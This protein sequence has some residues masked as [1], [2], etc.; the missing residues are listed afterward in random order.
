MISIIISSANSTLLKQVSKN[1]EATI[2]VPFE[3]VSIDN[4][5]GKK[6]ICEV[7]NIG[8][9]KA[10]YEI[11]CFMHEDILIETQNWGQSIV[12]TFKNNTDLGLLGV[13]GS[14]Y[15]TITP[16][17][18]GGLGVN[19]YYSNLIQYHKFSNDP[20]VH[21]YRNPD[22]VKLAPVA[23]VDG[24]W[25]CTTKTVAKEIMFDEINF[26]GFHVYDLDF[27]LSVGQKYKVAVTYDVLIAHFSEGRFDERWMMDC[28]KLH[29]KWN[30]VLPVDCEQLTREERLYTEKATFKH[31][32]QVL[33]K[34]KLPISLASKMLSVNNSF[35]KLDLKLYFKLQFYILKKRLSS[36]KAQVS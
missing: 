31:F 16:S 11:L 6:G 14:A 23:C 36:Y 7:Y 4:S 29:E 13:I 18:W 33:E 17:G 32:L 28:L 20:P 34:L 3:I 10:Q 25:M 15:K 22:N 30:L 2:G 8:M 24:V 27:S 9:Y 19:T 26:T 35:L 5:R 1:V 12:D 21:H